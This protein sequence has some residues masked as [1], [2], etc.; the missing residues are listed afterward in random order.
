[1]LSG[2]MSALAASPT[3]RCSLAMAPSLYSISASMA[4]TRSRNASNVRWSSASRYCRSAALA[5]NAS[6]SR[7]ASPRARSS[8][9]ASCASPARSAAPCPPPRRCV[10]SLSCVSIVAIVRDSPAMDSRTSDRPRSSFSLRESSCRVASSLSCS[11]SSRRRSSR[12]SCSV[13]AARCTCASTCSSSQRRFFSRASAA[14][15]SP[16]PVFLLPWRA[17]RS[18][19]V[20]TA[21]SSVF[22][23]SSDLCLSLSASNSEMRRSARRRA[24][25]RARWCLSLAAR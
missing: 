7:R 10:L 11:I 25:T 2:D 9:S 15:P 13:A 5:S 24:S 8:C 21:N 16:P 6:L 12:S 22:F 3:A 19:F 4:S 23:E 14:S 20:A 1:M 17:W 18:C